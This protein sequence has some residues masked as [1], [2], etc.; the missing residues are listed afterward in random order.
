MKKVGILTYHSSDNYGSVLQAYALCKYL[1]N[2]C[3]AEIIDYRKPEVKELYK[4]FKK[5]NSKFNIITNIYNAIY[6]SRLKKRKH[7]YE[8]F[9]CNYM[10]LSKDEINTKQELDKFVNVYDAL[11]CGSD[12]VWNF[13][14]IDFDT[15][16]MLYFP[17]YAGRKV[18]YAAS[19]GPC[20]KDKEKLFKYK[21]ILNHLDYISVREKEAKESLGS[22]LDK[23]VDVVCDPVFLLSKKEWKALAENSKV[24][25][26]DDYIFCYFP[27]GVSKS[28]EEFSSNLAKEKNCKRIL[29]SNEWRNIY[30]NGNKMYDCGPLDFLKLIKDAKYV[31]TTSFHGTAFA[32]IMNT[33]L[34]VEAGGGKGDSRIS[35]LINMTD[36]R[37]CIINQKCEN[38][39]NTAET[40]EKSIKFSKNFLNVLSE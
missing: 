6:Y 1:S 5:N 34:Y 39:D 26:K 15:S 13:D 9:R 32:T 37:E 30:R 2:F 28:M 38:S 18:S 10:N 25:I 3:D 12:Q 7:L 4:I 16:Y 36:K 14:I 21:D 29:I 19:L 31:C 11:V 35:T 24:N 33:S 22:V 40:L 8:E 20:E 27:G 23:N 17:D